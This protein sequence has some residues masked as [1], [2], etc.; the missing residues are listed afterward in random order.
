MGLS[1]STQNKLFTAGYTAKGVVYLLI[2]FF[3]VATVI[4][5][6]RSTSG[7]KDVI[8]WIGGN[9]LGQFL[10]FLVGSGLLA[11]CAWRWYKA[12]KDTEN[13]GSD[14]SG[15]IKRI[16]WAVSG[17]AYGIL[18]VYTFKE[19]FSNGGS[20]GGK[21]DMVATLLNQP[22]GQTLVAVVGII[23]AGVGIYQIYRAVTDRHMDNLEGQHLSSER[24]DLFRYA[25]RVG[26]AAQA[27]VYA[28][29]AYFLFRAA[30]MSDASQF[31]GIGEALSYLEN[32]SWGAALLAVVGAGLFAYGFFMF[33]RARY[34]HV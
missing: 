14:A 27:T 20:T 11:Y 12:V 4:G 15:T 31:K 19:L 8:D 13:E 33:V 34:E 16:G 28:V 3:A 17:T 2:G 9:P 25:G 26:L 18:S 1:K 23:V 22:W 5:A 21:E 7:P 24:E 32:G 6:A 30:A 10:L 29:I